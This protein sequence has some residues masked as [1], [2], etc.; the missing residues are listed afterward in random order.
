[1]QQFKL[2]PSRY[3]AAM[4][5]ISHGSALAALFPTVL[6]VWAK[7]ALSLLISFS[8]LH[9]L[10]RDAL[11]I[12]GSSVVGLQVEGE[13]I[14]MA[15][16]DG[17]LLEGGLLHDSLV[18]P[19]ITVLNVLPEGARFARSVVIWPDSLERE[20]FRQLRVILRWGCKT[21]AG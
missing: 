20:S 6:P 12:P 18:T 7:A 14:V 1:M 13:K 21:V 2:S 10:W 15:L 3:F 19:F 8:L 9:H 11:L 5:I 4:L 16:R 17:K